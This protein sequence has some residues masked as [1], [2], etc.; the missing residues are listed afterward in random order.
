MAARHRD[1]NDTG[2]GAWSD[3]PQGAHTMGHAPGLVALRGC[4]C[5]PRSGMVGRAADAMEV[6]SVEPLAE[7]A[8]RSTR[9]SH[10]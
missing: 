10:R 4:G 7:D 1:G 3:V 6:E 9:S 5:R 8:S 2:P